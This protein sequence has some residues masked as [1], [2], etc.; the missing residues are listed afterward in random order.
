[1]KQYICTV[2]AVAIIAALS[3]ILI[4]KN[5]QKY[6]GILTGSILLITLI[7]PLLRLRGITPPQMSFPEIEIREYSVS[8]EITTKLKLQV[9][10]DIKSRIKSEFN[11]SVDADINITV[12]DEKISGISEIY[13]YSKERPDIAERLREVYGCQNII[14]RQKKNEN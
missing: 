5:W 4:P 9:E 11:I 1:M 12:T 7:S 3:D 6:T 2:A 13:L 14:W 8:D 10:E